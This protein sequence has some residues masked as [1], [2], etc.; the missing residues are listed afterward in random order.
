MIP[1]I[2]N[3]Y[4]DLHANW[5]Q[6]STGCALVTGHFTLAV[7][8]PITSQLLD[9]SF[10]LTLHGL[11]LKVKRLEVP[12]MGEYVHPVTEIDAGLQNTLARVC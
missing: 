1:V 4:C 7:V 10:C 3:V 2:R 8:T 9:A 12:K 6:D 11:T 5:L